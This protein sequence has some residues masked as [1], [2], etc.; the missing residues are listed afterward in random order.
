MGS[1]VTT[2]LIDILGDRAH[3][4]PDRTA[5]TF[6]LDG[7]TQEA[8][9]T[10]RQLEQRVRAIATQL[11]A[12][13]APGERVL[14]LYPPGLDY[15]IAFLGCLYAGLVAVPAYPPKPNRSSRLQTLLNDAQVSVALTT[16]S[17]LN[18][19]AAQSEHFPELA[20]L[21]WIV[22]DEL[23]VLTAPAS[24]PTLTADTLALLQYTSGSTGTPK[25]V[26]VTHGNLLHNLAAIHQRFHHSADS[27]GVIWLPPYHDMG[28][29]GGIL[30]PLYGGFPVVLMAPLLFM[31]SPIR[32]LRAISRYQGTTS[33]GPNFAYELC[34]RKFQPEWGIDLDLSSWQVAFNGA[35]PIQAEVM[36]RFA[37]TYAPYGFNPDA[38]HPCYGMA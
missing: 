13:C 28:L 11:Q 29:I 38:F 21:K 26:M 9:L 18:S 12:C 15:I 3:H 5:Y 25:G 30:Q 10:Y 27:V 34:V 14:L 2:T 32:W 16:R 6:L 24:Q 22:S 1:S 19:L 7:D 4:H 37:T 36:D 23:A 20:T 17:V 8:S 31:Q 33:G 35:E